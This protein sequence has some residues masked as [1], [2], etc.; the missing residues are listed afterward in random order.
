MKLIKGTKVIGFKFKTREGIGYNK[1]GMDPCIGKIGTISAIHNNKY[2]QI[3]F[4]N[5]KS[6]W[7]PYREIQQH[8]AVEEE[9]D[10]NILFE[11]I[12]QLTP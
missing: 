10:I 7:Y 5:N 8:L 4:G 3:D 12:K 11:Q 9:I 1:D 6:F 2:C